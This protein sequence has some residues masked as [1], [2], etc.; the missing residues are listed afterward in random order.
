MYCKK[1]GKSI[2]SDSKYCT[3][4]GNKVISGDNDNS[5]NKNSLYIKILAI[6]ILVVLVFGSSI[7]I[8]K[9]IVN[10]ISS[11]RKSSAV[12]DKDLSDD[13]FDTAE[14][15]GP[16]WLEENDNTAYQ[17]I[18][19]NISVDD[20]LSLK[21]SSDLSIVYI[22]RQSCSYCVQE[23]MILYVLASKYNLKIN[24]LDISNISTEE[25][26]KLQE[27]DSYFNGN[28]GIPV[29]ALVQNNKIVDV[30][31][32]YQSIEQLMMFFNKNG[33]LNNNER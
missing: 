25:Y 8:G 9:T 6:F 23:N 22:A 20:Y 29:I 33:L 24:Y 14:D 5:N 2:E 15:N 27:S 12:V 3:Y 4:C 18:F 13:Y 10:Y 32:G 1:C 26:T 31:N 16:G 28:W 30:V 11:V 7:F 17:D 21:S 19:N